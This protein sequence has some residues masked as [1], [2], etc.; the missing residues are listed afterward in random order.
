MAKLKFNAKAAEPMEERSFILL[1]EDDYVFSLI[2]SEMKRNSKDT[3]DRLNFQAKVLNGEFKGNIV[4]I[5]LNWG[6][7]NQDAQAISDR[8]FKSI[9]DVVGKGDEEIEETEELHGIPFIGTI[10]H[11]KPSGDKYEEDGIVKWQYGPKAEIKKYAS[12]E[13]SDLLDGIDTSDSS[14]TEGGGSAPA[15]VPW[16]Q[17]GENSEQEASE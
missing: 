10:I 7:P 4:F 12:A 1:P 17:K 16:K 3:A 11:S 13:G 2:K 5:G 6:H 14:A 8:E 9:C 15:K